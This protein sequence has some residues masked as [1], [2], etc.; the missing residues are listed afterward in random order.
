M[1]TELGAHHGDQPIGGQQHDLDEHKEVE[2]VS[3][4]QSPGHTGHQH[5]DE[6]VEESGAGLMGGHG[7]HDRGDAEDRDDHQ[8][9]RR[10]RIHHERDRD[11][12]GLAFGADL[13]R[14]PAAHAVGQDGAIPGGDH[15]QDREGEDRQQGAHA[16]DVAGQLVLPHCGSDRAE[17]QRHADQQRQQRR[18]DLCEVHLVSP[19]SSS[20]D[21]TAISPDSVLTPFTATSSVSPVSEIP[22]SA[23][24]PT[25]RG[26]RSP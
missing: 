22:A 2:D 9:Q 6:R 23:G 11:L 15:Q 17:Q 19:V 13:H 25:G 12:E 21:S 16:D 7:E 1:G 26:R 3:G 24:G 20:P 18:E 14:G 10:E 8:H 5:Q 4:H